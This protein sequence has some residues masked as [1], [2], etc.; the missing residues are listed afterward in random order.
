MH[1]KYLLNDLI[2]K[3]E[4]VAAENGATSVTSLRVWLG[5]LSHFRAPHF[6]T[7]F[8]EAS[9]HTVAHNA[10]LDIEESDDIH[11]TDAQRVRLVALEVAADG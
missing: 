6:R 11:H 5:A 9:R 10:R 1:E 3:V 7:H 2:N 4:A 8:Q